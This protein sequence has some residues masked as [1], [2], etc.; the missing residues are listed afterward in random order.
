MPQFV[1]SDANT[2][3]FQKDTPVRIASPPGS[4][5]AVPLLQ[6]VLSRRK[7]SIHLPLHR[8]CKTESQ[9][10]IRRC[11]LPQFVPSSQNV[12]SVPSW[13][14]PVFPFFLA[15]PICR[16]RGHEIDRFPVFFG[17]VS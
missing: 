9:A 10:R 17:A 12:C 16:L 6:L 8:S 2:L 5:G 13:P 11:P 15:L 7:G 1:A 3:H 4:P 14:P